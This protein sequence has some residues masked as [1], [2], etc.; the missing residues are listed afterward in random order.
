MKRRN[1]QARVAWVWVLIAVL[2]AAGVIL[3]TGLGMD[4]MGGGYAI[5]F[6]SGFVA[7][8]GV[9]AAA[10]F[11]VRARVLGRL[12]SGR[13]VLARWTYPAEDRTDHVDKE[14]AEERKGSWALFLVIAAF[15]V[16]I[17]VGF[18]VADPDAGRFVFLLLMGVVALLAVVAALA[19]RMRHR[20]RRRATPEAIVSVEGAY[21]LG[22]LH[23]WRLLGARVEGAEVAQSKKPVLRVSYSAPFLYGRFFLGR[24]TYTVSVP[25]PQGEE[26]RAESVVRALRGEGEGAA[27]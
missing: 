5:A 20:R 14:L 13:G 25:I 1:P 15:S 23:T 11:A 10:I 2:G 22:M 12:F 3:P 26:E 4:G 24:Q 17:G 19:P 6:V 27:A 7:L 8:C 9:V 18:L 21:V 16:V